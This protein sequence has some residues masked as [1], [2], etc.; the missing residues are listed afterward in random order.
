MNQ[1]DRDDLKKLDNAVE[2]MLKVIPKEPYI[3]STPVIPGFEYHPPRHE[4]EN[5][6]LGTP[7]RNDEFQLQYCT[8]LLPEKEETVCVARSQ[9]DEE[10]D[11]RQRNGTPS[12]LK[13]IP[14]HL[15]VKRKISLDVYNRRGHLRTGSDT[16][17][18]PTAETKPS[19][20]PPPPRAPT[21]PKRPFSF[22]DEPP[23]K[24]ARTDTAAPVHGLPR[25]LSPPPLPLPNGLPSRMLSPP[26][27]P[28]PNGLPPMLSPPTLRGLP[29]FGLP[30]ML[31]PTLP[32]NIEEALKRKR[33]GS[34]SSDDVPIRASKI[35]KLD[36]DEKPK[37]KAEPVKEPEKKKRRCS[38]E[39][40]PGW[41][42]RL[43]WEDVSSPAEPKR[44]LVRLKIPR[45]QRQQVERL[46]RLK[47]KSKPADKKIVKEEKWEEPQAV[48]AKARK[49]APEKLRLDDKPP[50]EL[51]KPRTTPPKPIKAERK[52]DP[53][54]RK[55]ADSKL[56][57]PRPSEESTGSSKR[58]RSA[59]DASETT[60]KK[61]RRPPSREAEPVTPGEEPLA[62]GKTVKSESQKS[63]SYITPRKDLKGVAM[64][65]T[66][67][68]D[69]SVSTPKRAYATPGGPPASAKDSTKSAG[70]GVGAR[71]A[72]LDSWSR[73]W[74]D[75]GRTLKRDHQALVNE[76]KGKSAVAAAVGLECVLAYML[77][78]TS[79]DALMRLR[80]QPSDIETS[81]LTLLP[82]YRQIGSCI[83]VRPL[84]GLHAYLGVAIC[85]RIAG[86][87]SDRVRAS[88]SSADAES[89]ASKLDGQSQTQSQASA[90]AAPTGANAKL[91]ADT[92]AQLLG[93][94]R[95]AEGKLGLEEVMEC[96]PE[97]WRARSRNVGGERLGEG[98]SVAGPWAFPVGVGSE[99]VQ[100]V[101]FG[102]RLLGE[103]RKVEGVPGQGKV[104]L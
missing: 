40:K 11:R 74:N 14:P 8:F 56:A 13:A 36:L 93:Y 87:V 28:L 31:S 90:A 54:A 30:P 58:P 45:H 99:P 50:R 91:L 49:E 102:V 89:P 21:P 77:A 72:K 9:V 78:F 22:P 69:S 98:E 32:P 81:W 65:R 104:V 38:P 24:K 103:W 73:K 92:W 82:L 3:L 48:K 6:H 66:G 85:A 71:T 5:W 67:S 60:I 88:S 1:R 44:L 101:R 20:A 79:R 27:L 97:T 42:E 43:D 29:P 57:T 53:P 18:E 68:A 25:M 51:E 10:R 70:T 59:N 12:P 41:A 16:K 7:F 62:V 55:S 96:F 46:L 84:Q 76:G 61:E 95:E 2:R 17:L 19:A 15:N 47:P 75:L 23:A 4:I 86:G 26:P 63:A 33:S 52:P 37:M 80:R 35:P 34:E 100:V 94:A 83:T 39:E 64:A